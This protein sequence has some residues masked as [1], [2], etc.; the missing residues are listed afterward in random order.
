MTSVTLKGIEKRYGDTI[1]VR[2]E[3]LR[4]EDGDVVSFLG[5]S[6]CGKT[7]TLRIIAGLIDQNEGDVYFGDRLVNDVPPEKRNAAMVFQNYA[8][9]PHM[10]V[11][12][13]VAFGLVVQKMAKME[14]D[15]KVRAV[16]EL[17][18]LPDMG[19]RLP[20]Q[21]SGGQ[22][23]RIAV[24]RAL[25]TEPDVLLFDEPLSNL[26]AKLREYM[27]FEIR[28]L[29]EKLKI[30]TIYVTHDQMEAMVVSDKIVVMEG[31]TIAQSDSPRNVYRNPKTRF[32]ADFVGMTSFIPGIVKEVR[33]GDSRVCVQTEDRL[34]IWGTGSAF[35][36][37]DGVLV[38]IRPE[39]V[40]L[41]RPGSGRSGKNCFSGQ[42]EEAID[43]GEFVD[44]HLQIGPWFLRT[45]SFN[46]GELFSKK[47]RVNVWL[48]PERCA[49]VAT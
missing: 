28:K 35:Q 38:C 29:L 6:G 14:I 7:T 16:L 4:I 11:Y 46:V 10:S 12:D 19:D 26:D 37:G 32:V 36:L 18:Q 48:D 42:I 31:G 5:P 24:A 30:T 21:L 20:K 8:L 3:D 9:F 47:D 39:N 2:I 44:Y 33:D 43:F 41:S 1:A 15:R 25:A 22:Q 49:V 40:E 27:R 34:E 45:K 13:N 17:V 23:Q